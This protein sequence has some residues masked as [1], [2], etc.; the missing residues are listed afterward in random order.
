MNLANCLWL[1]GLTPDGDEPREDAGY[2]TYSTDIQQHLQSILFF[3]SSSPTAKPCF[4]GLLTV[5]SRHIMKN[6]PLNDLV[7]TLYKKHQTALDFIIDN[8]PDMEK[9]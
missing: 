7:E 9:R 1:R 5:L 8:L 2:L 3:T 4:G 6:D